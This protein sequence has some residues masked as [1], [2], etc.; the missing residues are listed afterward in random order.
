M[1]QDIA[2]LGELRKNELPVEDGLE[3]QIKKSIG[4]ANLPFLGLKSGFFVQ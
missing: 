1:L 2:R 3:E 4:M